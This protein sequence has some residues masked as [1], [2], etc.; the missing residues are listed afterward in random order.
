MSER[1]MMRRPLHYAIIDEVDSILVDEARTPM[2]ISQPSEEATDKY[3]YY[4][5]LIPLLKASKTKKKVKKGFLN[6]LLKDVKNETPEEEEDDGGDYYIDEKT[7]SVSLSSNGIAK[8]E[9][10]LKVDNL[11]KDIGYQEIHHI[12]NALRAQ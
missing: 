1:K 9:Q 12:E 6:E 10:F 4:A 3:G 11:Y 5:Q 2:I 7:K 8:L